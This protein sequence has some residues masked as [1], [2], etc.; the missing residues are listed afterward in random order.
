MI[1]RFR[2]YKD[3]PASVIARSNGVATKQ[4]RKSINWI[5]APLTRLAMT[6]TVMLLFVAVLTLGGCL[7]DS[8]LTDY[9]PVDNTKAIVFTP[10]VD[11]STR[12]AAGHPIESGN[13]IPAAGSFG[14]YAYCKINASA[15]V[16][17]YST[18][19]NQRVTY[20]GTKFVYAPVANWPA[21]S[22]AQL[23][24]FGYFPWQDQSAAP[25]AGDPVIRVTM[26]AA[27]SPSMTIAYTTPADPSKQVDLMY[28]STG[29]TSGYA[30]VNLAFGH[31]LTRIN[32]TA[33]VKDYTDPVVITKITIKDVKTKGTLPVVNG[34][35]PVWS[36]LGTPA[37]M[38][39]TSA[40]G[41]RGGYVLTPTLTTVLNSGA[42]M[43]VIPQDI[44]AYEV[45]VEA[46]RGGTAFPEPFVFPLVY[47]TPWVMNRVVTYDITI[48]GGGMELEEKVTPWN[49]HAVGIIH[50]GQWWMSVSED[51]IEFGVDSE[52]T[53]TAETNY[54]ISDKGYPAG[55]QVNASEI[56]YS[57]AGGWLTLTDT[58]AGGNGS[59][60]RSIKITA[61]SSSATERT[62]KIYVKAGNMKK[63]VNVTQAAVIRS[64]NV[65]GTTNNTYTY[66]GG[67]QTFNVESKVILVKSD[68]NE[69]TDIPWIAEF[70]DETGQQWT[71]T[72]PAW[73]TMDTQ[74]PG[75]ASTAYGAKATAFP[76][77]S[78]DTEIVALR[79]AAV[80][81]SHAAPFDLS[82]N[83]ETANCYIVNAPGY[84]KLPLV[85]GNARKADGTDNTPSYISTT[86]G[87]YVLTNFRRHD[88]Q[89]ITGPYIYDQ[90]AVDNATLVWMDA[91]DLIADVKL[92]ADGEN[93]AFEV[94]AAS[95]IQG[96]AIV[97]V[98]DA[99]DNILWSWHIWVT[100]LVDAVNP[101][102]DPTESATGVTYNMMQ[103]N[104]GWCS[105]GTVT[106]GT[107]PRSVQV[108]IRQTGT[109]APAAATFTITQNNGTVTTGTNNPYWQW[110]RKDPI[111]PSAGISESAQ[112]I[113]Y[114]PY[115]ST[116]VFTTAATTTFGN[117]IANPNIIFWNNYLNWCPSRYV[118]LWSAANNATDFLDNVNT[119]SVYDPSPAGF[120]VPPF[121][122]YSGFNPTGNPYDPAYWNILGGFDN[123]YYFYSRLN[124][125]G[126]PIFYP[127]TGFI[128]LQVIG[129]MDRY[130]TGRGLYWT[131]G[132]MNYMQTIPG[133]MSP[134][135]MKFEPG[136]VFNAGGERAATGASIRC[137]KE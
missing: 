34:S 61:T 79:N 120:A 43:L 58:D 42:D 76:G 112:K 25:P 129:S 33:R 128:Y 99:G 78:T 46:T 19:Q 3:I 134:M 111:P 54:S 89:P 71:A 127:A 16:E 47:S 125:G 123:G 39:L 60:S 133:Y 20:D 35:A 105:G 130:G 101:T 27:N 83:G 29:L 40:N 12:A 63:V 62:A 135:S 98:R 100:P 13:N 106:Y 5:A 23:A 10:A 45:V 80:V 116:G 72:A 90:A 110:G 94:P 9:V 24:F 69:T 92:T 37:D 108:R 73:F 28:A 8:T 131:R 52:Y 87:T 97:A 41:L 59:L 121:G 1:Q 136:G 50:D 107:V 64:F 67:T 53:L 88:D 31:A 49:E 6:L 4:S 56:V 51:D 109:D 113:I 82:R 30:P 66:A 70:W 81:G 15:P 118:N 55:L 137:V 119:K 32:F 14:A 38:T 93:L 104:L 91:V 102:T 21:P 114:G 75:G 65:T 95:I 7:R 2:V 22:A 85:Y 36:G 84:Y 26:G 132:P 48:S 68:G 18:L 96:N 57:D 44:S 11:G 103:Y 117:S 115:S 122:A 86:S 74:G 77:T 17:P 124:K 126:T